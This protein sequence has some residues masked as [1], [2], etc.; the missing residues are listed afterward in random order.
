MF[1]P[2]T[3]CNKGIIHAVR[4]EVTFFCGENYRLQKPKTQKELLRNI[5]FRHIKTI[6]CW[7]CI[8]GLRELN[9]NL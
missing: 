4:D 2:T 7:E 5:Q 8:L 1:Y 3:K 6:D 9:K